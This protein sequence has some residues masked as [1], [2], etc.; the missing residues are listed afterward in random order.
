[1]DMKKY[2]EEGKAKGIDMSWLEN[3]QGV[4]QANTTSA[5]QQGQG[6]LQSMPTMTPHASK[7]LEAIMQH[8]KANPVS[9]NTPVGTPTQARTQYVEGMEYTKERDAIGDERYSQEWDYMKQQDAIANQLARMRASGGGGSGGGSGQSNNLIDI[10]DALVQGGE[11]LKN[12]EEA[13]WLERGYSLKDKQDAIE[14]GYGL[15]KYLLDNGILKTNIPDHPDPLDFHHRSGQSM[16]WLKNI[17]GNQERE[18]SSDLGKRL[19]GTTEIDTKTSSRN[20]ATEY[21]KLL[22]AKNDPL[23]IYAILDEASNNLDDKDYAKLVTEA[24]KII[25]NASSGSNV[26]NRDGGL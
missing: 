17:Q 22:L 23:Q 9:L 7:M 21:G 26:F 14:H 16:D 10:V 12:I 6:Q 1:M 13:V 2:I 20:Y 24:T 5:A 18:Y 8:Q 15:H 25:G 3:S 4:T 11:P 19:G